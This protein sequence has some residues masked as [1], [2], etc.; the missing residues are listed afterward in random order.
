MFSPSNCSSWISEVMKNEK[1]TEK[2]SKHR[3]KHMQNLKGSDLE[4]VLD[5]TIGF[6]ELDTW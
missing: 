3:K 4:L 1:P 6:E 2:S 5:L